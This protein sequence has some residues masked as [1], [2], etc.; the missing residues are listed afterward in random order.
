MEIERDAGLRCYWIYDCDGAFGGKDGPPVPTVPTEHRLY[1]LVLS[2]R[3]LR[4]CGFLRLPQHRTSTLLKELWR[5]LRVKQHVVVVTARICA[6]RAKNTT[7]C[8]EERNCGNSKSLYK[9][10]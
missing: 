7:T 9:A 3:F 8:R 10:R 5:R 1:W 4:D 6:A 2:D